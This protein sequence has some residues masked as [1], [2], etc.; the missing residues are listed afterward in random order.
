[1]GWGF[2][3]HARV[4]T[5]SA[6]GLVAVT[7]G[8]VVCGAVVPTL[9]SAAPT[10]VVHTLP[11]GSIDG[12]SSGSSDGVRT[13]TVDDEGEQLTLRL[14][15]MNLRGP[16][17]SMA[18]QESGGELSH[19]VIP[20]PRSYIG[21]VEGH[22]DAIVSAIVDSAGTLR[23]QVIFDRGA[24]IEFVGSD[25]VGRS[26]APIDA[27]PQWP[28]ASIAT[29]SAANVGKTVKQ[30]VVGLDLS[31]EWY[32]AH[33]EGSP[34]V[35]LDRA[36]ESMAR[37]AAIWIRDVGIQPILG[38]VVLRADAAEDPYSSSCENLEQLEELWSDQVGTSVDQ[39]TVVCKSGGGNAYYSKFELDHSYAHVGAEPDGTFSRVLRHELGHN[40]YADDYHGGG[41]EGSTIMNGNDLSRFDGTEFAAIV[42]AADVASAR[43]DDVG[44]YTASPIPP[45]A[46]LDT[47][48]VRSGGAVTVDAVANDHDSNGDSIKVTGVEATSLLGGTVKLE[49]GEVVFE[50]G[51]KTG[52]DRILYTLTDAVGGR[53]PAGSSS[54]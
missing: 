22:P 40:F 5:K 16:D 44:R 27:K 12:G 53:A 8:V 34:A 39:A 51:T 42:D 32:S 36:E 48:R 10:G 7:V 49:N 19:V 21:S 38:R 25:V 4:L 18:V 41:A 3:M 1:M 52:T 26:T 28:T 17:F 31:G 6:K 13:A 45:Y 37:T 20:A 30:F 23:G 29:A 46:A 14:H 24:S 47:A 54:T 15:K 50:A 11:T 43:L 2:T 9:A 33:G 35:A